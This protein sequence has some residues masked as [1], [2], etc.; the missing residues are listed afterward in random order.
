MYEGKRDSDRISAQFREVSIS[1]SRSVYF[2]VSTTASDRIEDWRKSRL[3]KIKRHRRPGSNTVLVSGFSVGEL[4]ESTL[5]FASSFSL[6]HP[7]CQVF[8]FFSACSCLSSYFNRPVLF[9]E[10]ICLSP[11]SLFSSLRHRVPSL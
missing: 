5:L 3:W 10:P 8:L 6:R 9:V 4:P 7:F 1:R 2:L 11:L